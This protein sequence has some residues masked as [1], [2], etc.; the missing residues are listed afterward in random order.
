MIMRKLI[1]K[2]EFP[3]PRS[4]TAY[5][6]AAFIVCDLANLHIAHNFHRTRLNIMIAQLNLRTLT[7]Y[8]VKRIY[9]SDRQSLFNILL[10]ID[11]FFILANVTKSLILIVTSVKK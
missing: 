5:N 10:D 6:R 1:L 3:W 7:S 2:P 9:F 8:Y 11:F 4:R